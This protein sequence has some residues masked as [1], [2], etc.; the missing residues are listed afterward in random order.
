MGEFWIN[1]VR[2]RH[3]L[4]KYGGESLQLTLLR[5]AKSSW[6]GDKKDHERPLNARGRQDAPIMAQRLKD[7]NCVPD[8][9]Y[10]SS[11]KRTCQTA[12]IFAEILGMKAADSLV[13]V[14][15]LY[16]ATVE[17]LLA[18]IAEAGSHHNVTH[19]MVVG[20]NPG[21]ED[22]AIALDPDSPEQLPTC[23]ICHYQMNESME[24]K[25]VFVDYPKLVAT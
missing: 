14:D 19:L 4:N 15:S 17:S 25:L 6:Q 1:W 24:A 13:S 11:A 22:L 8:K 12:A 10:F 9:L 23:A 20:H 3:W 2:W 7:R 5:H 18:T 16:L 21:L